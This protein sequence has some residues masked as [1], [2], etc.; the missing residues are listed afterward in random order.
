M[1]SKV[2]FADF[3]SNKPIFFINVRGLSGLAGK[4]ENY[5]VFTLQKPA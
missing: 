3:Q 4:L 5:P 2:Y 1:G